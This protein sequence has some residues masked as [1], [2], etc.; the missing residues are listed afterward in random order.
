MQIIFEADL[1]K[2]TEATEKP[3][4]MMLPGFERSI[5]LFRD[6]TPE[7]A[8]VMVKT[9]EADGANVLINNKEEGSLKMRFL[10]LLKSKDTSVNTKDRTFYDIKN[11]IPW[12]LPR[13]PETL[14]KAQAKLE[15]PKSGNF[16]YVRAY[17]EGGDTCRYRNKKRRG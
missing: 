7:T 3:A 1:N 14:A 16:L 17:T 12:W 5:D 11:K 10:H 6:L 4:Q 15:N 2:M 9:A 8:R 13:V